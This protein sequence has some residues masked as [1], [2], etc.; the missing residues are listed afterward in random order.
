MSKIVLSRVVVLFAMAAALS[1]CGGGGSEAPAP[2]PVPAPAPAPNPPPPPP[3]V[4]PTPDGL[5]TTP[6]YLALDDCGQLGAEIPAPTL[7]GETMKFLSEVLQAVDPTN[8]YSV[9][10]RNPLGFTY[11]VEKNPSVNGWAIGYGVHETT[12]GINDILAGC[13]DSQ[14]KHY[15]L[16]GKNYATSLVS[17]QTANY[18]IADEMLPVQLKSGG[19]YQTYIL[20]SAKYANEFGILLDELTAY[21]SAGQTAWAIAASPAYSYLA[22]VC[23]CE[24]GGVADF[25]S[26]LIAYLRA[27][28]LNHPETYQVIQSQP[29]TIGY[30]QTLWLKAEDVL[31][32]S[33]PYSSSA[34]SGNPIVV[35][36]DALAWSF[37]AAQLDELDRLGIKHGAS[38]RWDTTYL[39]TP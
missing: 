22:T 23:D 24:A 25:M 10:A 15:M 7:T 39:K 19:R 29:L 30:M 3:P 28:R 4:P 1:A 6:H 17:G 18:S 32:K 2:A 16:A 33:Y 27:A 8:G 36:R 13:A 20:G 34:K 35:G 9:F 37:D 11:W 21:T 38:T 26:Y 12:H 5:V 31:A 14:G